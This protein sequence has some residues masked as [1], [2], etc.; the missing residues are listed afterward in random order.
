MNWFLFNKQ[1]LNR[2]T[3]PG[4]SLKKGGEPYPSAPLK[5]TMSN[6]VHLL[7]MQPMGTVPLLSSRRGQ[8]W[9]LVRTAR[10]LQSQRQTSLTL[11][12]LPK[13]IRA[14]T[15]R[16]HLRDR[17]PQQLLKILR[18]KPLRTPSAGS[19]LSAL[20]RPPA[21][22]PFIQKICVH[23]RPYPRQSARN[24]FFSSFLPAS[25][26]SAKNLFFPQLPNL[27]SLAPNIQ[28]RTS[29]VENNHFTAEMR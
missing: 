28:H 20:A 14:K 18:T 26:R 19:N 11:R 3:T 1:W 2:K 7:T 25:A 27:T 9:L 23:L 24:P 29:T 4:P 22:L 5:G 21:K 8:G 17:M 6:Q 16:I 15:L 13:I 10:L 12:L